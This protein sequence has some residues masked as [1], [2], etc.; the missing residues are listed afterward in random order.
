MSTTWLMRTELWW[1]D[2]FF[3]ALTTM[4]LDAGELETA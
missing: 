1:R 2:T 3:D 4:V